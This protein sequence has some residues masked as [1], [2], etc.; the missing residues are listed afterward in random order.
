[1]II[2]NAKIFIGPVMMLANFT[3]TFLCLRPKRGMLFTIGALA[4]YS[5]AVHF[6]IQLIARHIGIIDTFL[7]GFIAILFLPMNI[8]LFR[9]QVFQK[10]FAFFMLYQLTGLLTA[11]IEALLGLT[12]GYQNP[13]AQIVLL[14]LSLFLLGMYIAAALLFGR[15]FLERMFVDGRRGEWSV[16]SLCAVFSYIL[17]LA[18]QWTM[19]NPG[20]YFA[21]MLF[22]LWNN[23]I[24][25]FTIINTHEKEAQAHNAETLLVQ[26]NAMR[27]QTEAEKKHQNDMEILRHDMR[28]EMGIMEL[29]RTGKAAEA[30]IVYANWQ[31]SLSEKSPA[32]YCRETLY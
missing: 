10:V 5:A 13:Y 17:V 21:L 28:H 29:F 16:Y 20:L 4:L 2:D 6:L 22:I 19:L 12:I 15:R 9:G 32:T 27:E 25:C 11:L 31:N 30:E 18:V 24:L 23:G 1:M 7:A 3:A 26:M 14:V 8:L